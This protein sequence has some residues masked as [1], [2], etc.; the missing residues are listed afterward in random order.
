M[1]SRSADQV[2]AAAG[3]VLPLLGYEWTAYQPLRADGRGKG[4]HRTVLF[5]QPTRC[6][7]VRIPGRP[8]PDEGFGRDRGES[9]YLPDASREIVTEP[10]ALWRALDAGIAACDEAGLRWISFA[11]HP[12]Y[13]T[14]QQNDWRMSENAPL[15]EQLV[16]IY[17]EHGSSEC[18]DTSASGCDFAL[19]LDNGHY[20]D[21]AVQTA[22]QLGFRLGFVAG[23]DGHDA[24]PGS[25]EDGPSAVAHWEDTDE[26]GVVDSPMVQFAAGGLTGVGIPRG[27]ALSEDALFDGL[28]ARR[29][30]ATTGPR[31]NFQVYA[32]GADGVLRPPGAL[33]PAEALPAELFLEIEGSDSRLAAVELVD[34]SGEVLVAKGD[35]IFRHRW[36]PKTA[37]AAY[38]R[39]RY[40][41]PDAAE[42]RVWFSP[43]FTDGPAEARCGCAG[44]PSTSIL[45]LPSVF[46]ALIARRRRG[47][48]GPP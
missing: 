23:T 27:Q 37:A 16:E 7:A 28:E 12:A 21:G 45:L 40:S 46:L 15:R 48:A 6:E 25:L 2:E 47:S 5:N 10:A 35:R 20:P 14:P 39:L 8:L 42:D 36:A 38:L 22:R 17:S 43:W 1:W 24:R 4:S 34:A 11:H 41:G 33:L 31:P 19:N 29:T 3:G 9:V 18:A 13:T 44:L 32:R 26:D 30:V